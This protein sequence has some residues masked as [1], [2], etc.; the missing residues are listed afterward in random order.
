[1]AVIGATGC[2]GRQICGLA[3][4]RGH[5]VLAIARRKAP[6]IADHT[7]IPLDVAATSKEN[8]AE[9]LASQRVGTVVNAA[10]RW[11]PTEAEMAHSHLGVVQRL[12]AAQALLDH[13][14]R[15]VHIGSIHEYGPVPNG[16]ALH[17][18]IEPCPSD[19]YSQT[20]LACSMAVLASGGVVLRAANMF[21]PYPPEET[22]FASLLRRLRGALRT[23]ETV[24]LAIAEAKR[25]FVD[26]RDVATAAL[27]AATAPV[28]GQVINIGSGVAVD[29]REL[30]MTFVAA[31][32]F[33][34]DRLRTVEGQVRSHGGEWIEVD[35]GLAGRLLGWRPA[36]TAAESLRAMWDER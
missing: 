29:M 7:F 8:I 30:V 26:V 12:V 23:G 24:E 34:S 32:G 17:E 21:G 19:M 9:L 28:S 2:V 22:F 6:H 20:K 31:A 3:A 10:G 36:F 16:T 27:A 11:G 33:P 13:A 25:D 1:M 15:L 35:I 14:P 18:A 4:R 5:D